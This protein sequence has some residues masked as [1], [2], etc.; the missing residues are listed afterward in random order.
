M[1]KRLL[2]I[3]VSWAL[4]SVLLYG[5]PSSVAGPAH[6]VAGFVGPSTDPGGTNPSNFANATFY[7]L[8][9]PAEPILESDPAEWT[10]ADGVEFAYFAT[11]VGTIWNWVVGDE[12]IAAWP[13]VRT[14][15][16]NL[17]P[18]KGFK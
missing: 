4:V 18:E 16:Y 1:K 15:F 17:S 10:P 7:L 13:V 9:N 6:V 3:C 2:A 14:I 8:N 5:A 12:I 11:D